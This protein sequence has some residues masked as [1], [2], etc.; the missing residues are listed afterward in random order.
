MMY[1]D[2]ARYAQL[3]TIATA[4]LKRKRL[5]FLEIQEP[6]SAFTIGSVFDVTSFSDRNSCRE[7]LEFTRVDND[8]KLGGLL[9]LWSLVLNMFE[10][11]VHNH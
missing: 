5:K 3:T 1:R 10:S 4:I 11:S 7:A 6:F 2:Q 8:A 9:K